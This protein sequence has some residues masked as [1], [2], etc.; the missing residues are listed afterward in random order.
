MKQG[1]IRILIVLFAVAFLFVGYKV[2]RL[3][4]FAITPADRAA[5]EKEIIEIERGKLPPEISREL[6]ERKLVTSARQILRLG[7]LLNRWPSVKAGEYE[8]SRSMSPLQILG[9]FTSGISVT[10]PLT[11]Q[12]GW[13]LYQIAA[14]VEERKLGSGK[15]FVQ[16]CK[17]PEWIQTLWERYSLPNPRPDRLEG[18]LFPNTYFFTKSADSKQIIDTMVSHFSKVWGEIQKERKSLPAPLKNMKEVITLASLVEKETGAPFER[19][20]ISSVF[21]NR[22]NKGIRLQS[23]PTTIYGIWET[24]NGNLRKKH[25]LE[26][27]NYNTY[28]FRGLPVGPIANPGKEAILAALEPETSDYLYFVSRNDGTHEFTT[29]HKDHIAAVKK[30]QLD[31]NA[32]E[33]KSWRDLSKQQESSP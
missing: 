16:L 24:F 20:T 19:K 31:R 11:V 23:D 14:L 2:G 32:R 7:T 22:L 33:G 28:S 10:R 5:T 30:F 27:N 21:H 6:Q 12:E 13:N 17:N 15:E 4:L 8:I 9:V 3:A 1:R 29:N 25:L 18:F 26:K